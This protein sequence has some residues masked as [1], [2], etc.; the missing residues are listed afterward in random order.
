L[1]EGI[2]YLSHF[3]ADVGIE[4]TQFRRRSEA[5]NMSG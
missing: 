3:S 2:A 4:Y 1:G 5:E